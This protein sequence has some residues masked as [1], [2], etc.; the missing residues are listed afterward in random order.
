MA[1]DL[2]GDS[3]P[4][5]AEAQHTP[6]PWTEGEKEIGCR[7]IW[8]GPRLIALLPRHYLMGSSRPDPQDTAD[9]SLIA[10]APDLLAA[11]EREQKVL[12]C[13]TDVTGQ[14]CDTCTL[15]AAAKGEIS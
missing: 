1:S 11:L 10:A 13:E 3:T 4:P 5:S 9:F 15:I 8:A 12:G 14:P 7:T 6:L 2:K